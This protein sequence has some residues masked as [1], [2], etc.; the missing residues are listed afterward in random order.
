MKHTSKDVS[1]LIPA[2]NCDG[3][4][5]K[6]L[7]SVF[8]QSERVG[9]VVI[10]NDG[11]T[12]NTEDTILSSKYAQDIDY[13]KIENSG[14]GAARNYGISKAKGDWIAFLDSDDI[15]INNHKIQKQLEI[16]NKYEDAVLI[17]GFSVVD[18]GNKTIR[19][20]RI[21]NGHCSSEFHFTNAVNATSS[22]I[23]S[24]QAILSVGGFDPSIRFGEDRLLWL[25]L[26]Y[27]GKVY[28]LEESVIK[29]VNSDGNLTSFNE[30]NF[31]QR[32]LFI[33]AMLSL[34][35]SNE[36]VSDSYITAISF[37]NMEEF[38]KASIK[39]NNVTLFDIVFKEA[40]AISTAKLISS[41][42]F[43]L[44]LYRQ[45]IGS[46]FPFSKQVKK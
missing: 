20:E 24:R 5:L 9:Q 45:L 16:I 4:I 46:F 1:V 18:W 21:K 11:S 36:T 25:A 23:A 19:R 41:R 14:P 38:F 2:Y 10:V 28:T 31:K 15:W 17:D 43:P 13:Y 22:V 35:K 26:S 34:I 37:K 40:A 42:Y 33:N 32:L 29:K 8:S 30:K 27:L 7:D 39:S 3:Y 12:D 6:A 44:Y